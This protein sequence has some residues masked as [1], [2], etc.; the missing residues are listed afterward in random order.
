M[1]AVVILRQEEAKAEVAQRSQ[2][3]WPF[4]WVLEPHFNHRSA[5]IRGHGFLRGESVASIAPNVARN[6]G[7]GRGRR[8]IP[9]HAE[10]AFDLDFNVSGPCKPPT[11]PSGGER[12]VRYPAPR[13][14]DNLRGNLS[15]VTNPRRQLQRSR[16]SQGRT[17]PP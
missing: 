13:R 16:G 4:H 9:K 11:M 10:F 15:D 5:S 17:G 3:D 2:A 1:V 12:R 14:S 8:I 7:H 6:H